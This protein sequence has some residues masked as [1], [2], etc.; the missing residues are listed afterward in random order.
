MRLGRSSRERR[1]KLVH[2]LCACLIEV[3][4]VTPDG[5]G[6][7]IIYIGHED[8]YALSARIDK[9]RSNTAVAE[10]VRRGMELMR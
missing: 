1:S 4:H 9:L 2:R 5:L 6:A 10:A 7:R 3:R 8:A